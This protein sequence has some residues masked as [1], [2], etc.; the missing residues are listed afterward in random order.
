MEG[1]LYHL[2]APARSLTPATG[3]QPFGGEMWFVWGD[4][5]N[6]LVAGDWGQVHRRTGTT[7]TV[8]DTTCG[9]TLQ[10]IWT[11]QDVAYVVGASGTILRAVLKP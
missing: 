10:G 6:V 7:W 9:N 5:K 8:E 4:A 11:A 2:D 1:K 3:A